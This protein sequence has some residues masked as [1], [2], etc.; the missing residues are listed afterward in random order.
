MV[1]KAKLIAC[2]NALGI[3]PKMETFSERKVVQK[4]VYLIQKF[5]IDLGFYYN[6]YLHGPYSPDLTRLLFE[7]IEEGPM[8]PME[9]TQEQ[10]TKIKELKSFLGEDFRSS[11]KLELIVSIDYLREYARR[12]RAPDREVLRALKKQKPYFTEQ[13]I[14]ECW[15]KSLELDYYEEKD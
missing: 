6:W 5:G 13:E 3:N 15:Q 10:M 11:D 4:L 2:L 14:R 9:L 1:S 12:I 7:I 8:R